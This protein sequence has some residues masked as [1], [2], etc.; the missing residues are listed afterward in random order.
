M[1]ILL[2]T[3]IFRPWKE[4]KFI[5]NLFKI[6]DLNQLY[7]FIC[8][9]I[10]QLPS[11]SWITHFYTDFTVLYVMKMYNDCYALF[12]IVCWFHHWFEYLNCF[13]CSNS[14]IFF[15]V[16][17]PSSTFDY[18]KISNQNRDLLH[19]NSAWEGT[20]TLPSKVQFGASVAYSPPE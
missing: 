2:Y 7:Q 15:I 8:M 11:F 14:Q 12:F 3:V 18:E 6:K 16:F 4:S 10:S 5:L 17:I 1:T 20:R 13:D 19:R 9:E